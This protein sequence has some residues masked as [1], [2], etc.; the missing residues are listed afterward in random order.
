MIDV[1]DLVWINVLSP[2]G[3]SDHLSISA[4]ISMANAGPN[5]CDSYRTVFLKQQLNLNTVLGAVCDLFS[6]CC[7]AAE[8]ILY[9][10][11][12]KFMNAIEVSTVK[13][14]DRKP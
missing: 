6:Y 3:N 7:S 5:M 14:A 2:I 12:I 4:V 1:S 8:T 10:K 9:P 13:L 11:Q